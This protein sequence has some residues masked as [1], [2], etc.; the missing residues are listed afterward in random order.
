[1]PDTPPLIDESHVRDCVSE[2]LHEC[3]PAIGQEGFYIKAG[4]YCDADAKTSRRWQDG[5]VT[6][7]TVNLCK[8]IAFFAQEKGPDFALAFVTKLTGVK[9]AEPDETREELT[10]LRKQIAELHERASNGGLTVVK[11]EGTAT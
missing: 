5:E 11:V 10:A 7:T 3:R 2:A 4:D 1:M 8:L 6:I 9:L